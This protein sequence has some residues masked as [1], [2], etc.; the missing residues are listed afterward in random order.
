MDD[1]LAYFPYV[2][3]RIRCVHCSRRGAYRLARL[4]AKYGPEITLDALLAKLTADC[5]YSS[6]AHHPFRRICEA[7]FVDLDPP[8]RPPDLPAAIVRP[9]IVAGGKT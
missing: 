5:E 3:V 7:R 9:R 2:L 6:R 1:R 4:A 8:R